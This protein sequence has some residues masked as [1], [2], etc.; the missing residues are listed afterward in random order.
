MNALCTRRIV[1][2]QR[3]LGRR[4]FTVEVPH[5]GG[6]LLALREIRPHHPAMIAFMKKLAIYVLALGGLAAAAQAADLGDSL[7]DPLPDGPITWH[8]VTLYGT[9]DVGGAYQTHGAKL[10]DFA[11]APLN[12]MMFGAAP[13]NKSIT[14]FTS[15]ALEQSKLGVKIDVKLGYGL[16]AIGQIETGFVPTSGELADGCKSILLQ[17]GKPIFNRDSFGD[18]SRCGQAFNGPVYAGLSSANYGT[19]TIGRQNSLELDTMAKYDPMALSF[20]FSLLGFTGNVSGTGATE[21]ARW[22]DSIKYTYQ[23]GPVHAGAMYTNGGPETGMFGGG[24]GFN[25]GGE[26]R[27]FSLDATYQ[28]ERGVVNS[29]AFGIP[30]PT[31]P[32]ATTPTSKACYYAAATDL[33]PANAPGN[34]ICPNGLSGSISDDS[35]WA[36]QA[37]YSF[38]VGRAHGMK[39]EHVPSGKVTLYGGFERVYFND[40]R[41]P[42]SLGSQTIGGYT[43]F[44]V[45]NTPF[46]TTQVRELEWG[47]AKYEFDKWTTTVAYYHY[48]QNNTLTGA[49]ANITCATQTNTNNTNKG[50]GIFFGDT[51]AANCAGDFNLVSAVLDYAWTKHFDTYLGANYSEVR[52]GFASGNL[53]HNSALVAAGARLKF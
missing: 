2:M 11:G 34:L 25:I 41:S 23:Y 44:A 1:G 16:M 43:L 19:L 30:D 49:N 42:V 31:S 6:S 22:D 10:S 52:G 14:T 51:V 46:G 5:D 13:N 40:P 24:Y 21:R 8:G 3:A 4:R 27:G 50:K 36:I 35:S 37:K 26:H 47:G 15:N 29:S 53:Q 39:D 48:G 33:N 38:N 9:V 20:A 7:K 12:Y 18:S 32:T 45:N 17:N 28:M